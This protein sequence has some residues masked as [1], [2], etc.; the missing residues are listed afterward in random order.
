[1]NGPGVEAII[2]ACTSLT[3]LDAT[4]CSKLPDSVFALLAEQCHNLKTLRLRNCRK[5]TNATLNAIVSSSTAMTALDIGGCVRISEKVRTGTHSII[6][7]CACGPAGG[8]VAVNASLLEWDGQESC[9]DGISL[10]IRRK[11][12]KCTASTHIE[13]IALIQ[14]P[15]NPTFCLLL[16]LRSASSTLPSMAQR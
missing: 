10:D 5:L 7:V 4:D 6:L 15:F 8:G 9:Q 13:L 2:K 3:H 16:R 12:C 14:A 1:M 11:Q